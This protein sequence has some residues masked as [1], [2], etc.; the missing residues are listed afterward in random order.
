MYSYRLSVLNLNI[1]PL[2]KRK[3]DISLLVNYYFSL[4]VNIYGSAIPFDDSSLS[5][6]EEHSWDGNIRELINF[7]ERY[8]VISKQ[9]AI[10]PFNYV[11]DYLNSENISNSVKIEAQDINQVKINLGTL[12]DMEKEMIE[13]VIKRYDNN[14]KQAAFALGISRTTLYKKI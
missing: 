3:G 4:F 6:L 7:V 9:L 14:K 12:K 10:I 2:R 5:R 11:K 13:A 1:P 8:V